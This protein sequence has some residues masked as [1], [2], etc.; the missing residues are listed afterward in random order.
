MMSVR[1]AFGLCVFAGMVA[2]LLPAGLHAASE[3]AIVAIDAPAGSLTVACGIDVRGGIVGYYANASGT[4]GFLYSDGDFVTITFPGTAWTA[5]YGINNSGQIVGAYGPNELRGRHGFLRSGGRFSSIDFPGST[6]TVARGINSRGQI[7]GDYLAP[8]GSRRGFLLSGGN[9]QSLVLTEG[10]VSEANGINDRGQ[11]AGVL[12]SGLA[13]KGVLIDSGSFAAV[14]F[15]NTN[16]TGIE[17]INDLGDI[18]GKIDSPKAPYRGFSRISGTF[19]LIDLGAYPASW[20]GRGINGL[21]QIVGSYT[22]SDGRTHGYLATPGALKTGPADPAANARA[23]GPP[24]PQGQP[25]LQGPVGPAGPS[26]PP[27]PP[28][29]PGPSSVSNRGI[30]EGSSLNSVREAF[31]RAADAL[32]KAAN[33]A[34]YVQK[35]ISDIDTALDD[36]NAAMA[37]SKSHPDSS[38][39]AP[40]PAATRPNFTA[41]PPPAPLRNAMLYSALNSLRFAY[42]ALLR[43]PGG[44]IGGF[45]TKINADIATAAAGLVQGINSYNAKY[46]SPR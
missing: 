6:D 36:A 23:S 7:V 43:T 4:H 27:G 3:Y 13:A 32:L 10:I 34:D 8:D 35:A 25:G 29:P 1:K 2:G 21:G 37:F 33:Q 12:G 20:E 19:N 11:I 40:S 41:T 24:G 42:D 46:A 17:G 5:A 16:Y 30:S 9:Y 31:E 18:V 28:G 26:G 14:E 22:G 45:R 38:P 39:A 15:P 44:D